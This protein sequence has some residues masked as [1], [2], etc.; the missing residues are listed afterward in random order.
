MEMIDDGLKMALGTQP[1]AWLHFRGEMLRC[2]D[3]AGAFLRD[4]FARDSVL[5]GY[6]T[7]LEGILFCGS[8]GNEP[9]HHP[10]VV[11]ALC[12]FGSPLSAYLCLPLPIPRLPV[13]HVSVS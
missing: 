9:S 7:P 6:S 4:P 10:R 2:D 12:V 1:N 11:A 8:Q 3:L 5:H 13:A